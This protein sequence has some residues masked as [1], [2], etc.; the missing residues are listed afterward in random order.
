MGMFDTIY[1]EK[2]LPFNKK[3]KELFKNINWPKEPSQTKDLDNSLLNYVL[4][5]NGKFYNKIIKG[6]NVRVMTTEEEKKQ[7]KKHRWVWPFEFVETGREEKLEKVTNNLL[8]YYIVKDIDGNDWMLDFSAKLV[9][10]VLKGKIKKERFEI[11]RTKK[12]IEEDE[13]KWKKISDDYNKKIS[14]RFRKFMNKITFSY[15]YNFWNFVSKILR[16]LGDSMNS[17]S[18]WIIRNVS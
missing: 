10:G 12:E 4:K 5:K 17:F 16:R 9:D 6:E 2:E 14:V 8:F 15:W 11:I 1:I 13:K 18:F 7:R 3:D